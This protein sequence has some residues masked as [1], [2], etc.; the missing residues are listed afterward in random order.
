M[1]ERTDRIGL[2]VPDADAAAETYRRLFDATVAGDQLDRIVGARRVTLQWGRDQVELY[3]P[4][5]GGAAADF[6]AQGKRGLFTGG[7]ALADPAACATRLER[8]GVRV[9]QESPERYVVLPQDLDGTGVVLTRRVEHRR[10]GLVDK[11]WQI[12]YAVPKLREAVARYSRLFGVEDD[13]TNFY[14]SN[15]FGYDGAIT[16]FEA[17]AGAPLDSLEYLE[18]TDRDAAVAR[19]VERSGAGIYM[20]SIESDAIPEIRR[21]VEAGG[22]GWDGD[23]AAAFIHPRRL[24]GLLVGLVEYGAWNARRPLPGQPSPPD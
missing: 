23:R 16:W 18:P 11:I 8:Q 20:C 19:F 13:F 12:T 3:Q 2:V 22:P 7:F 24:H 6:L 17:S 14:H 1:L 21:R 9:Y 5:G 15:H 4:R 10:V